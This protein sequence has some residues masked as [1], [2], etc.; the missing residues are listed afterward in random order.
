MRNL[1]L[2]VAV[3][4]LVLGLGVVSLAQD[5]AADEEAIQQLDQRWKEAWTNGDAE[6]MAELFTEDADG[7]DPMGETDTG[8]AAI[9][10]TYRAEFAERPEGAQVDFE[11]TYLRFLRPDI[12]IADGTWAVTGAPEA[13]EGPPTEGLY[14][15]VLVKKDG[16]WR[17]SSGLS[18]IPMTPPGAE[19]E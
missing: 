12:A 14:T 4:A 10:E 15:V 9:I 17:Y 2:F 8:R 1:V 11:Q 16:Q 13:E 18:R 6:A 7:I 3:L 5:T 19:E